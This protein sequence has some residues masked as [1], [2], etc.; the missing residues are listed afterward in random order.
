MATKKKSDKDMISKQPWEIRVI[1]KLKIP[2]AELIAAKKEV[3][4]G[5]DKVYGY[6]S[7]KGWNIIKPKG[8]KV[9]AWAIIDPVADPAWCKTVTPYS[10]T[11]VPNEAK[12]YNTYAAAAADANY[13]TATLGRTMIV[14]SHPKP[15]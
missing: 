5:R 15:H 9:A 3:G 2:K 6:L 14:G 7:A 1:T 13:L 4:K 11:S 8:A 10:W 12:Q